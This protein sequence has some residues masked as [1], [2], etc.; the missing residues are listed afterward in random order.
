MKEYM[1]TLVNIESGDSTNSVV[2]DKSGKEGT[3]S[4]KDGQS[5]G[6]QSAKEIPR[7]RKAPENPDD[8][9]SV[10]IGGAAQ[11]LFELQ[12]VNGVLSFNLRE[13]NTKAALSTKKTLTEIAAV[14]RGLIASVLSKKHL[15]QEDFAKVMSL[16]ESVA[17]LV[18]TKKHLPEVRIGHEILRTETEPKKPETEPKKTGN[19]T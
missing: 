10:S 18:P 4:L 5:E 9:L 7:K 11:T 3:S 2:G 14:T 6:T 19:R 16:T 13:H 17:V 8:S 12:K 15:D 1:A